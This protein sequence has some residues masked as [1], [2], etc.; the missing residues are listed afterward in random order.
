MQN[1]IESSRAGQSMR[2]RSGMCCRLAEP[3]VQQINA[4]AALLLRLF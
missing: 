1:Q 3:S 2:Q 4:R